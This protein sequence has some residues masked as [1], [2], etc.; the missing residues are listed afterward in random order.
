MAAQTL[1]RSART[2]WNSSTWRASSAATARGKLGDPVPVPRAQSLFAAGLPESLAAELAKRFEE[3]EP[4]AAIALSSLDHRLLDERP[5]ELRDVRRRPAR[6]RHRPP[7]PRRARTHRRTRTVGP[8]AVARARSG[9]GSSS[10]SRPRASAAGAMRCGPRCPS[11]PSRAA[12]PRSS[13][14]RPR[15]FEPDRRQLEGERD[16]VDMGADAQDRGGV[17]G[18]DGEALLDGARPL[19]EQGHGVR[20]EEGLRRRISIVGQRQRRHVDHDLAGDPEGLPARGEDPHVGTGAQ[21]RSRQDGRGIVD[22]LAVVEDQERPFVD[23]IVA[24]GGRPPSST[25][26]PG[27]RAP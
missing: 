17:R 1:A 16:A 18:V 14:S 8:T 4:V 27:A 7:G 26:G 5:D 11:A 9:A 12:S 22:V 23:E 6:R 2:R 10:R 19:H 20:P 13:P 21:Q 24:E 3:P 25:S 15:A